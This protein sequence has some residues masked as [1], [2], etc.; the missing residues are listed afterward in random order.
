MI[1]HALP[2]AFKGLVDCFQTIQQPVMGLNPLKIFIKFGL[3]VDQ[4]GPGNFLDRM[5]PD[6]PPAH[7]VKFILIRLEGG[8]DQKL[9]RIG[10]RD[11]AFDTFCSQ[12]I[13]NLPAHGIQRRFFFQLVDFVQYDEIVLMALGNGFQLIQK[14]V[15][16]VFS[17]CRHPDH[18]LKV[19]CQAHGIVPVRQKAAVE[20]GKIHEDHV[21]QLLAIMI[22]KHNPA[23]GVDCQAFFQRRKVLLMAIGH[24]CVGAFIEQVRIQGDLGSGEPVDHGTL[25]DIFT[26]HDPIQK[27]LIFFCFAGL[28]RQRN[29]FHLN[30]IGNFA[31]KIVQL[32][33]ERIHFHG[34]NF[35]NV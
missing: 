35:R 20:I 14:L 18:S 23:S 33:S 7:V 32:H 19:P 8:Q 3:Q 13:D 2:D 17:R 6:K 30:Q 21:L 29:R 22:N 4:F 31:V 1:G 16:P 27:K 12:K 15:I 28:M 5:G 25:P 9:L 11:I 10:R 24:G 34:S 26:P